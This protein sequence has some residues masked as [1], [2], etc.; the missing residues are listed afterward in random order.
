MW[1]AKKPERKN[2]S[3]TLARRTRHVATVTAIA[4]ACVKKIGHGPT[5]KSASLIRSDT[6]RALLAT[7]SPATLFRSG[8]ETS[9]TVDCESGSVRMS[10]TVGT[11][12]GLNAPPAEVHTH[13]GLDRR[14]HVHGPN[15]MIKILVVEDDPDLLD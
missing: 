14:A 13:S 5:V 4:R 15:A 12:T 7:M 10:L 2:S 8:V 11:P 1:D 3:S 6:Q 9:L